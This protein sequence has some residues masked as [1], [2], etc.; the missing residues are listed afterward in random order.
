V[1]AGGIV[2]AYSV[3]YSPAK[4]LGVEGWTWSGRPGASEGGSR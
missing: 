1:D 4:G 2:S 3:G